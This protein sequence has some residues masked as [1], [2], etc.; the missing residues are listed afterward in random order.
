MQ[1]VRD[2]ELTMAVM[3]EAAGVAHKELVAMLPGLDRD[4]VRVLAQWW[5]SHFMATGHKR[6]FRILK[7]EG[8]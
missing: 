8:L 4:T 3:E 6:L 7:K 2:K 5:D 1:E